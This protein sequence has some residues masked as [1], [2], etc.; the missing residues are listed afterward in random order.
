MLLV[1]TFYF[2]LPIG[3]W[4]LLPILLCCQ[5]N[6]NLIH[7]V[8]RKR[9][10]LY[11]KKIGLHWFCKTWHIVYFSTNLVHFINH[12]FVIVRLKSLRA[13]D[14]PS[15]EYELDKMADSVEDIYTHFSTVALGGSDGTILWHHLPKDFVRNTTQV[16]RLTG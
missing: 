10:K 4:A 7:S 3:W 1:W 6:C 9:I 8:Q 16:I 5:V 11:L 15:D 14:L 12:I 13:I 2:V